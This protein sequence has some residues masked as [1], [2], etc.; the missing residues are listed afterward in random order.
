VVEAA[1]Q[2]GIKEESVRKRIYRGS[3]RA[4]K[5]P[6]G[7][8]MVYLDD[9]DNVQ[10][11]S[12]DEVHG[13]ES[14][15]IKDELVDVLQGEI[16]HLRSESERKDAIIMQLSQ[17]TTEQARTIR[18]LEAPAYEQSGSGADSSS[19]G[20]AKGTDLPGQEGSSG[21]QTKRPFWRRWFGG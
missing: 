14:G 11:P 7:S 16:A 9:V 18:E 6:D 21:E 2:L 12:T 19:Q 5:E 17:A 3:L 13:H 20:T 15:A 1:R 8:L 10:G 4:D